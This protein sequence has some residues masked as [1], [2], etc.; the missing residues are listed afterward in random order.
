MTK[1]YSL[2]FFFKFCVISAIVA[3]VFVCRCNKTW[4]ILRWALDNGCEWNMMPGISC[5]NHLLAP[6]PLGEDI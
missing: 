6:K 4:E 1:V 3:Y 5:G 2:I